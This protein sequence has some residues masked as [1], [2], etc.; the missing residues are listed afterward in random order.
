[1]TKAVEDPLAQP[2]RPDWR[3]QLGC[4]VAFVVGR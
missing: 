4:M 2:K 1:M 3:T